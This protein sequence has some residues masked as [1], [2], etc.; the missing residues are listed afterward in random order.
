MSFV[1]HTSEVEVPQCAVRISASP[2][3]SAEGR[4]TP[5]TWGQWARRGLLAVAISI[6][7]NLVVQH[8]LFKKDCRAV[9]PPN[10]LP[11]VHQEVSAMKVA[12][13]PVIRRP[14]ERSIEGHGT[15]FSFEE[16]VVCSRVEGRVLRVNHDVA[17]R[18]RADDLLLEL[19]PVDAQ[20]SVEQAGHSLQI[21]LSSLGLS[22]PLLGDFNPNALP[23][24]VS[25]RERV[26]NTR[27]RAERIQRLHSK[28]AASTAELE[29]AEC[30][31]RVAQADHANQLL[32]ARSSIATAAMRLSELKIARQQLK[33]TRVFV[34]TCAPRS[35]AAS[36]PRLSGASYIITRRAIAEG[37]FVQLGAELFRLAVDDVL[38]LRVAVPERYASAI[39]LGQIATIDS[40]AIPSEIVGTVTLVNPEIDASTRTFQ[41]EVQV[42]NSDHRLKPG[43]FAKASIRLSVNPH[44]S[45]VPIAAVT[46]TSGSP[47]VF[48]VE[49]DTVKQTPVTLGVQ[50]REW[51]EVLEPPL[52]DSA[53]VVV[54]GPSAL[55][56]GMQVMLRD[57]GKPA[58]GI[59]GTP[60]GTTDPIQTAQRAGQLTEGEQR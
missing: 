17:D 33:E 7:I 2:D 16:L 41:V 8:Y 9:L 11:P 31:F 39:T 26:D 49:G 24:V 35:A 58:T 44:A 22:E 43:G 27:S 28:Q 51:V 6:G 21:A 19:D 60:A 47:F 10:S 20:L 57:A 45:T 23:S 50:T 14:V 53:I 38:K 55:S 52:A 48:L 46:T 12:T 32:V 25:A 29:T 18:V 37:S 59:A 42:K 30:D 13:A 36:L 40:V 4:P 15:L 3:H 34:P 54:G 1:N 5:K 56:D